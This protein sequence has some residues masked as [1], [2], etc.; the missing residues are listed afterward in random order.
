MRKNIALS[1]LLI[2][3]LALTFATPAAADHTNPREPLSTTDGAPAEGITRGEGTWEFIM[4][5]APN[6][7]TDLKFFK[8]KGQLYASSGTLGQ[9]D[10]GNVGQRIIR[11]LNDKGEVAPEWV[12]DHG[13][14]NCPTANP[15]GTTGL[16]HDVAVTPKKNPKLLIDTTDAT[17]RCHDPGGGGLEF[18]T[19]RKLHNEKFEPREIHLTR[20]VGTSHTVTVDDKR[21]W[22]VYNSS[23]QSTGNTPWID[24]LDVRSCLKRGKLA[25]KRD[26]CR[27]KVYRI[28][29]QSEWS[30]RIDAAGEQVPDSEASCHDITSVGYRLYCANLNSTIIL[31]VRGL[32]KANGDV[33]GEP[34]S[35]ELVDGTN[36]TAKVTDCSQLPEGDVPQATGWKY[37]G[38]FNHPGRNGSHNT[39]T[40]YESTDG[41]SVAHEAEPSHDGNILFVTDE[42]G[43]GVIPG[44]S[45]CS[46][47]EPNPFGNGGVHAFD[48]SDPSQM[49]YALN[50][51]GEKAVFISEPV[52]PAPTFCTAH[53]MELLKGENRFSIAWYSQG[54]KIVDYAVDAQGVV[55]FE[56]VASY[57]LPNANTWTSQ[58]FKT[59]T[60]D[61]GTTTYYFMASDIE[62][63]IDIF[64]WTG[65]PNPTASPAPLGPQ[66][67]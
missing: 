54:T 29:F 12:A 9:A 55:T 32:T 39:N 2:I 10:E 17:G 40:E 56:E 59:V 50:A 62:R 38:H 18:V 37:L 1:L 6:P 63:G 41:I 21:P 42:R 49:D 13:S 64:S 57:T 51:D 67:L 35:C 16:Q 66:A 23:S 43:G 61:D 7:G 4:N 53:V 14:A 25:K 28:L 48:I 65:E 33:K 46:P 44:G 22:I 31:D 26:D 36:T 30:R 27:P 52:L 3:G 8:K 19:I 11:L 24:V 15:S 20:H 45:S 60:N 58:V 5:F 47:G 34:T